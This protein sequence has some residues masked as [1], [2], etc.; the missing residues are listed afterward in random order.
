ATPTPSHTIEA[1][2]GFARALAVSPDGRLLA[3]CGNDN[4]VKLWSTSDFS[5]VRTLS[6]HEHHVYNVAFHPNGQ[7]L[8]SGALHGGLRQWTVADGTQTRAM[9]CSVLFRHDPTFRADHGGI[10]GMTFNREGTTLAC[11]GIT[12]V[13]N[14]FAGIGNPAVVLFDWQT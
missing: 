4:F 9:D 12:N 3:S 8:V 5:L 6:G 11:T 10:R 13:T 7:H 2:R 1:H 14:A